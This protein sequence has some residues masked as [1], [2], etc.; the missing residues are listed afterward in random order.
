MF[1]VVSGVSF[2]PE[3]QMVESENLS[4]Y[5]RGYSTVCIE[6]YNQNVGMILLTARD[7]KEEEEEKGEKEKD[8][9][10]QETDGFDRIW[11]AGHFG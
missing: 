1:T 10:G 6:T 7:D 4:E 2:V 11:D 9:K 3:V 5:L 8:E